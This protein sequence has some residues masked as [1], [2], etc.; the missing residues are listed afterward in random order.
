[1]K[2]YTVRWSCSTCCGVD[3]SVRVNAT[4]TTSQKDV[5]DHAVEMV[6]NFMKY[7]ATDETATNGFSIT[8]EEIK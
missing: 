3:I 5:V 8:M 6:K 2:T 7:V 1:M 4:E